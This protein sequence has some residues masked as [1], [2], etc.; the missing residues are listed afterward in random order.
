MFGVQAFPAL[1][2]KTP[3][4]QHHQ[5]VGGMSANAAVA[6]AR[7]GANVA[8]CGPVGDDAAADVFARHFQ[9]EGVDAS[10][11]QG[12]GGHSSSVSAIVI[13]CHGAR[14]IFNHRGSALTAQ[15]AFDPA[16]PKRVRRSVAEATAALGHPCAGRPPDLG[17][18][19]P[20]PEAVAGA[21][22]AGVNQFA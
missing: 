1:P 20:N 4:H 14:M 7:L 19:R 17:F 11:M 22:D 10:R 9:R 13:D 8:F 12:L 21:G 2:T 6:L 18:G 16:W 15:A 3:A 5:G